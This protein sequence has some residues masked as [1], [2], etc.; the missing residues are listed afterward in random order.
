MSDR[1]ILISQYIDNELNISEKIDFVKEVNNDD[2]Y[3]S[4]A[5]GMLEMEMTMS[6]T[7]SPPPIPD[8]SASSKSKLNITRIASFTALAASLIVM[9]RVFF[10]APDHMPEIRT[11]HRFVLYHPEASQ[12]EVTGTFSGW[13]PISMYNAGNGYWQI[14]MPLNKG[15]YVY[16]YL[17]NGRTTLPDP[18]VHAKQNDGFG[19]ENSVISVGE[20]I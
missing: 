15:E 18:T 4:S 5:L 1:N 14:T 7:I 11:A 20:R 8:I 17:I 16:T 10:F 12:V 13:Q 6:H 2:S 9:L 3:F 19:G